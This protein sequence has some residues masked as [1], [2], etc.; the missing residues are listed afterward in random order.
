[1]AEA[2][3]NVTVTRL[4]ISYSYFQN[5]YKL[6][7]L[8]RKNPAMT[9]VFFIRPQLSQHPTTKLCP[10]ASPLKLGL[11]STLHM[12]HFTVLCSQKRICGITLYQGA[13]SLPASKSPFHLRCFLRD[14]VPAHVISARYTG[15]GRQICDWWRT[16]PLPDLLP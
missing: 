12:S 2:L 13:F 5:Y 15:N 4:T 3:L 11:L 14:D 7:W 8:A 6:F 10:L 1:M 9:G 16:M